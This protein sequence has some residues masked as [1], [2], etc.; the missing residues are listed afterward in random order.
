MIEKLTLPRDASSISLEHVN[1]AIIEAQQ[2]LDALQKIKEDKEGQA[3]I[4]RAE[5]ASLDASSRMV[6]GSLEAE[7]SPVQ[8]SESELSLLKDPNKL[9]RAKDEL[10]AGMSLSAILL[11]I[12]LMWII[13]SFFDLGL[14]HPKALA[15]LPYE[16]GLITCGL[17]T[18]IMSYRTWAK[19][20]KVESFMKKSKKNHHQ[21]QAIKKTLK[22]QLLKKKAPVFSTQPESFVLGHKESADQ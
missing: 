13:L 4:Q 10:D 21:N 1:Q 6:E 5:E 17:I 11:I 9:K 8:W 12:P 22:S 2:Y 15:A 3:E 14:N 18:M 16:I 20:K 7:S 19:V